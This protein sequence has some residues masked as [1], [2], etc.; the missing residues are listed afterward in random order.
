MAMFIILTSAARTNRHNR[1]PHRQQP[2]YLSETEGALADEKLRQEQSPARQMRVAKAIVRNR[3]LPRLAGTLKETY[4]S[5]MGVRERLRW[6]VLN[7]KDGTLSLW[8]RPPR[9]DQDFQRSSSSSSLPA[10][11]VC[12][13]CLESA[14]STW[15][16]T[17]CI[18]ECGHTFH[19]SCLRQWCDEKEGEGLYTCP[20][21]RTPFT[22]GR[23]MASRR[24]RLQSFPEAAPG[25]L[26]QRSPTLPKKVWQ[27]SRLEEVTSNPH[28]RNM[29]IR[30]EGADRILI[31]SA[32]CE[33]DFKSW[34]RTLELYD[35]GSVEVSIA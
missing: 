1:R 19:S 16:P 26:P 27:L 35:A 31:L 32:D 30:F 8:A 11:E 3:S 6:V 34:M 17:S 24:P 23:L 10:E 9:E 13:I 15:Q 25:C 20:S 4:H 18:K 22:E 28:F 2:K 12:A 5:I 7:P 29:F 21:C 14:G 33:S